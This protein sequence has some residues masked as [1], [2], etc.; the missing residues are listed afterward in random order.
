MNSL[1]S[2][3]MSVKDEQQC[4]RQRTSDVSYVSHSSMAI[5]YGK[6]GI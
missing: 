5:T 1:P 3:V 4:L 2:I 6:A